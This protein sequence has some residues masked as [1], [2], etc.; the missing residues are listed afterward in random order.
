MSMSSVS[1][2]IIIVMW[3]LFLF[4]CCKM[5]SYGSARIEELLRRDAE[6]DVN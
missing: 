1:P 4:F 3:L 6:S 2:N 5:W